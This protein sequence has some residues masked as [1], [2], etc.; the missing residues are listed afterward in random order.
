ME[1]RLEI[2]ADDQSLP[3]SKYR[4]LNWKS[5]FCTDSQ[6]KANRDEAVRYYEEAQQDQ[7]EWEEENVQLHDQGEDPEQEE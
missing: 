2:K 7:R 3:E 6:T 1:C 4:F 5:R